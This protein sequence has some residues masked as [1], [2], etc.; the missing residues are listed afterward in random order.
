MIFRSDISIGDLAVICGMLVAAAAH[1][2]GI[3]NRIDNVLNT[4][5]ELKRGRGL[6]MGAT[7]DWP[8]AVRRCFGFIHDKSE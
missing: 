2:F 1:Y 8:I 7:S 3:K 5:E 6:V 4:V